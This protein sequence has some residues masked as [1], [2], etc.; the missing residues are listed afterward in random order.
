[1]NHVALQAMLTELP[2][3]IVGPWGEHF[4]RAKAELDKAMLDAYERGDVVS[5]RQIHA[6]ASLMDAVRY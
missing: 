4:G 6:F 2:P 5:L 3:G 1:M